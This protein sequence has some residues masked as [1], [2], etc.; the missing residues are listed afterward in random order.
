M[1]GNYSSLGS[2]S[3]GG[4]VPV[5][6]VADHVLPFQDSNLQTFPPSDNRGKVAGS[7]Q[8]PRDA[9]GMQPSTVGGYLMVQVLVWV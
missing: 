5:A 4:S 6:A 3:V 7:F 8:P 1:S 2:E 9:D